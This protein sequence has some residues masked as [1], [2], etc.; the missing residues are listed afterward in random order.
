VSG[1]QYVVDS[2]L[3]NDNNSG[4]GAED[5]FRTI[6]CCI[7]KLKLSEP[8]DECRIR[9]GRYHE[10][11]DT[12]GLKGTHDKPFIIGGYG[13]ERPIWDGTVPIQ[14][15]SWSFNETTGICSASIQDDIF[16][17]LL[18][19]DLLTP[20]RWPNALWSDKTIFNNSHWGHCDKDSS[21]GHIIDD[22]YADLAESGIDATGSMAILNIGSW[23]TYVRP[24]LTHTS[25]SPD[26]TYNHDMRNL[27]WSVK[28]N[29]YYLEASLSL[30]DAP[31]EWFY[32][33]A[34]KIL[35]FIPKEGV[36]PDPKSTTLRGRTIDYGLVI[37]DTTWLKISNM[38][39]LA[40][41]INGY[42]TAWANKGAI[43]NTRINEIHLD[44]LKFKFPSSSH[45]ML[46]STD[47]PKYTRLI[48]MAH[49]RGSK[50]RGHVSVVNCTFEG[51]EGSALVHDGINNYIHNNFFAYNIFTGQI[52]DGEVTG[53]GVIHGNGYEEIVSQN[54]LMYNGG[55]EGIRP[56]HTSTVK[57]NHMVGH[58]AGKNQ[59]DGSA[60]QVPRRAQTGAN[61]SHNW[62]HDSP[63][64]GIRFDSPHPLNGRK[65]EPMDM[66]VIML[67]GIPWTCLLKEII[68]Q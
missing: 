33:K 58:C 18:D 52:I 11:V 32:D 15:E 35:Y 43:K 13:D 55:S 8:G 57:L 2:E 26:F 51:S 4:I 17:L 59:N 56:G 29:Q 20:A 41:N 38:T 53:G 10:V 49:Y 16:A 66:L 65:E 5:A 63:K 37:K 1:T 3:G 61:I 25:G 36:C 64:H 45:R 47:E 28:H 7:E 54:T 24:V 22:G 12:S 62:V 39:F 19:D 23:Q 42:S 27:G 48:S 14:P 60:I 68:I 46:G 21:Y 30:L 6:Q 44:S 67:F 50:V 34:T 9:S 40:A 31:E